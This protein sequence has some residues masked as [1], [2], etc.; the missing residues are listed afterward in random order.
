[1]SKRNTGIGVVM[2]S[3]TKVSKRYKKDIINNNDIKEILHECMYDII[4]IQILLIV[5][6]HI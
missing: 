4:T 5:C 3:N 2:G 1:M 6:I